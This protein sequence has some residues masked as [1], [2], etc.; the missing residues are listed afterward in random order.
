MLLPD[1]TYAR[2]FTR[3]VQNIDVWS[4]LFSFQ[5]NQI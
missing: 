5:V 4:I 2:D 3:S 1:S